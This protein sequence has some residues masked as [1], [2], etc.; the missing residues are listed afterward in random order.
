MSN[1]KRSARQQLKIA[2]NVANQKGMV[3]NGYRTNG[4]THEQLLAEELLLNAMSMRKE[5]I[6]NQIDPRRNINEE[7]GYPDQVTVTMCKEQYTR[8]SIAARVVQ[9]FPRECWALPPTVTEDEDAEIVTTFEQAWDTL[10]KNLL[11]VDSKFKQEKGNPIWEYF[12]RLDTLAGIGSFGV[13]LL[14][15]DDG[16]PLHTPVA[17]FEDG[18]PS[19]PE[20]DKQK[21]DIDQMDEEARQIKYEDEQSQGI[22]PDSIMGTDRQYIDPFDANVLDGPQPVVKKKKKLVDDEDQ[23]IGNAFP[24]ENEEEEPDDDESTGSKAQGQEE[25]EVDAAD[26]EENGDPSMGSSDSQ[27]TNPEQEAPEFNPKVK[28]LYLRCFDESLVQVVQYESKMTNPRF[29]Q[30]VR[31]LITLND[32]RTQHGGVGLPLASVYVHWSRVLHF[33]D[34]HWQESSSEVFSP[35]RLECVFNDIYDLYKIYGGGSEGYWKGSNP[36]LSVET[37]PSLG[38]DVVVDKTGLKDMLE[39]RNN[40]TTKDIMLMGMSAKTL[41]PQALDPTPYIEV[42]LTSISIKTGIP[43]RVLMGSERGELSSG[44]DSG[45]WDERVM[46]RNNNLLTPRLIV[47]FV[48]RMVAF[49]CLPE[50]EGYS[51]DWPDRKSA[52]PL[53]KAQI[54]KARFEALQIYIAGNLESLITPMDA[55]T[56]V[57][58]MVTEEEAKAMLEAAEE[59]QGDRMTQDPNEMQQQ[60]MDDQY[61]LGQ[62]AIDAGLNPAGETH[63]IGDTHQHNYPEGSKA[64]EPPEMGESG[65][66]EEDGGFPPKKKGP[67]QF[68]ELVTHGGPGSGPHKGSPEGPYKSKFASKRHYIV[69]VSHQGQEAYSVVADGMQPHEGQLHPDL[70]SARAWMKENGFVHSQN[71]IPPGLGKG[72]PPTDEEEV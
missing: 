36:S 35:P 27:E 20:D 50:P 52:T 67:P 51:V 7:C 49:E 38:G 41:P 53:E 59:S 62:S 57:G 45:E 15:I 9:V 3:T 34:T 37:H 71:S 30:P 31:Y 63:Q 48:D 24:Q 21:S 44:Q 29:G 25:E 4:K 65:D 55:L 6:D 68:N 1:R 16:K 13:M 60:Q 14:G 12:K 11:G 70:K 19:K 54:A 33:T 56:T 58:D 5:W 2:L 72:Q 40:S 28:L 22:N 32:P 8:N 61:D 47:P 10:G 42:R 26:D 64:G 17:G 18:M 23:V 39:N 46:E 69:K 66:D 43:K